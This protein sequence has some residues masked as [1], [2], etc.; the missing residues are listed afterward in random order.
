MGHAQELCAVLEKET[1]QT[2]CHKL[3]G[4]RTVDEYLAM[5][6]GYCIKFSVAHINLLPLPVQACIARI[7]VKGMIAPIRR[8]ILEEM[9]KFTEERPG[10]EP[11]F[12]WVID[13]VRA[14]ENEDEYSDPGSDSEL[15][16]NSE[17]ALFY[18]AAQLAS[19]YKTVPRDSEVFRSTVAALTWVFVVFIPPVDPELSKDDKIA[20]GLITPI[21]MS[22]LQ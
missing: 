14:H 9:R 5:V 19:S 20:Q 8:P 11:G 13:I 4:N 1:S 15:E 10:Q 22:Y 17:E 2:W 16:C 6:Q 18:R 21:W 12:D 7:V 3:A